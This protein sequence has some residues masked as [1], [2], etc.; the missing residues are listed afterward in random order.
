MDKRK[1]SVKFW[2]DFGVKI[3]KIGIFLELCS[4]QLNLDVEDAVLDFV[5]GV[6][7]LHQC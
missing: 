6:S 2:K 5:H 3:G 4:V 1:E 7:L